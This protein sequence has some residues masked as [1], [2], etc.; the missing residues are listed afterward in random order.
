MVKASIV[1]PCKSNELNISRAISSFA[2]GELDIEILI[3]LDG[4]NEITENIILGHEFPNIILLKFPE[5]TGISVILNSLIN[6]SSGEYIIRMDAD[7]ISYPDRLSFQLKL[8]DRM[9]NVYMLCGNALNFDRKM[10]G[11]GV[12]RAIKC[13]ELLNLNPV[14]HPTVVFRRV[15]FLP[16]A[17]FSYNPKYKKSQD[18][19][20][21]TRIVRKY[22]I[23]YDDRVVLNYNSVFDIKKY[24][25][26]HYYFSKAKIKNLLWHVNPI[27]TC[28]CSSR[29]I[30]VALLRSYEIFTSYLKVVARYICE[31]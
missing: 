1:I 12:S 16:N 8:L 28:T 5:G 19:E 13:S 7:D 2:E 3:G 14:I 17:L 27:H 30:I 25:L 24:S 22:K 10:I 26:Q 18:Y 23:Y 9:P 6:R 21:W 29:E 15:I 31:K 4:I 11:N 20:L